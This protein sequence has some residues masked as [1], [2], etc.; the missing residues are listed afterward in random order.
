MLC[1]VGAFFGTLVAWLASV[2]SMSDR[3]AALVADNV[4]TLKAAACT[5]A[6]L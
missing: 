4:P 5:N 3:S 1:V 2:S 6:A